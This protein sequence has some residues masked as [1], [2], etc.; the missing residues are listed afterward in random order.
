CR[1][2]GGQYPRELRMSG[3]HSHSDAGTALCNAA[4]SQCRLQGDSGTA[5][6]QASWL[7]R[8]SR[9]QYP[10]LG[11]GRSWVCDRQRA[12]DRWGHRGSMIRYVTGRLL[13]FLPV[14]FGISLIVFLLVR[15]IPGDPAI[16][17]LGSRA[18]PDL[19]ARMR[20]Q[21]GLDLP[22]WRQYFHFLSNALHGNFGIS[23]F[24]Q[25]D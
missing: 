24:Y 14:L 1:R 15:L 18:T 22:L 6:D 3:H 17:V 23:Y 5:D 7:S 12:Y 9:G 20:D 11:F 25:A 19:I 13:Q 16:A 8:G 2:C 21:L 4:A 10:L